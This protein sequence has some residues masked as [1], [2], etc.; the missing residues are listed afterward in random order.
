M[1]VGAQDPLVMTQVCQKDDTSEV[2]RLGALA[3]GP[4]EGYVDIREDQYLQKLVGMIVPAYAFLCQ[5]TVW[6]FLY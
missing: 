4:A 3:L 6:V 2:R 5:C 1:C